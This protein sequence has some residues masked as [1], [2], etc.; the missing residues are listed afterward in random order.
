MKAKDFVCEMETM[1]PGD[2][3]IFRDC[4]TGTKLTVLYAFGI[5]RIDI[6]DKEARYVLSTIYADSIKVNPYVDEGIIC[7]NDENEISRII[8]GRLVGLTKVM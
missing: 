5:Y 2:E 8:V 6:L 7:F 4:V 3:T 1:N